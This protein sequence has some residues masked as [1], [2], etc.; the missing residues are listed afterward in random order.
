MITWERARIELRNHGVSDA[1]ELATARAEIP[2]RMPKSD[3][4]EWLYEASAV[5]RW[6]GY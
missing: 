5:L 2:A 1:S 3:G 4:G 6:L